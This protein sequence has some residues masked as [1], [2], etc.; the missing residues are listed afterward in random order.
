[1]W[2]E[3]ITNGNIDIF[4]FALNEFLERA[5]HRV[6]DFVFDQIDDPTTQRIDDP[7]QR[8]QSVEMQLHFPNVSNVEMLQLRMTERWWRVKFYMLL[9]EEEWK[10]R[11]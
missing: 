7:I 1:M 10:Q 6:G 11:G 2:N 8:S 9:I 4:H 3:L 5:F